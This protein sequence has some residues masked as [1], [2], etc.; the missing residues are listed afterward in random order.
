MSG[1]SEQPLGDW[2]EVHVQGHL[3]QR[4]T[5]WLDGD[6]SQVENGTTLVRARVADQAALHGLLN[7]LGDLGLRLI[8]VTRVDPD[9]RV[10]RPR[11]APP[12]QDRSTT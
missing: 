11:T 9:S 1:V 2:Y 6:L 3:D 5:A 12:I 7:K 4:W 8:S 10:P